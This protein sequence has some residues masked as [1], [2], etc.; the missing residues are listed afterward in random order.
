VP[1]IATDPA[2]PLPTFLTPDDNV[3]TW[4]NYLQNYQL[5]TV[6]EVSIAGSLGQLSI[7]LAS[8]LCLVLLVPAGWQV[9][10]R[11]RNGG[12]LPL[13]IVT[14]IAL[15][16]VGIVSLPYARLSIA[17]PVAIAGVLD[18]QQATALLETLL[19]NV[20]RAFDFREEEDV[21]DK[22]A[23]SVAGDLLAD[24]YLE[25]R[26][27]FAVQAAGG[28]QA[29]VKEVNIQ[30]AS[31]ERLDGSPLGYALRGQWTAMGTVGHW[32]HVHTRQN[33]YDAIVTIEAID[34]VWKITDLEVIEENRIDPAAATIATQEQAQVA[35]SGGT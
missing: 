9:A 24:V 33:L 31:A 13:P 26:R 17:R 2:G 35:G 23:I 4:T 29:K 32:G 21:Y 3:H 11:A 8:L 30:N 18:D 6:Q 16:V 34:G 15:V 20:Y 14:A 19:K 10:N 1:A 12:L 27:S 28:A 7:P 25:N 5:P 22:L